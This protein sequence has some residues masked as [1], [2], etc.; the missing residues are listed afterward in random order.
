MV[1][2]CNRIQPSEILLKTYSFRSGMTNSTLKKG[3]RSQTV[4][5]IY[6]YKNIHNIISKY[7]YAKKKDIYQNV[8][9]IYYLGRG[10]YG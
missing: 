8:N 5:T 1:Y 6:F 4:C 9:G 10:S 7:L 2:S 3:N